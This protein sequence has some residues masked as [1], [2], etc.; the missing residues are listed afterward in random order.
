M[1]YQRISK[2]ALTPTSRIVEKV[3]KFGINVPCGRNR[4]VCESFLLSAPLIFKTLSLLSQM[5]LLLLIWALYTIREQW[6]VYLPL[7]H[8]VEKI[9]LEIFP[10]KWV[11]ERLN[12]SILPPVGPWQV[13]GNDLI[14]SRIHKQF[15]K[16]MHFKITVERK[17]CWRRYHPFINDYC[18]W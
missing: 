8:Y 14:E 3:V 17:S 18:F 5:K 6:S 2:W 7:K 4:K 9:N 10:Y 1:N 15:N 16:V 13:K 12:Q 11:L